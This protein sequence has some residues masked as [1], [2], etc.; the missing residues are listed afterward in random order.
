MV[1]TRYVIDTQIPVVCA[2]RL[3]L[4]KDGANRCLPAS[5]VCRSILRCEYCV[6][7]TLR[8]MRCVACITIHRCTGVSTAQYQPY[9][10]L[11]TALIGGPKDVCVCACVSHNS[12]TFSFSFIIALAHSMWNI[13]S[14]MCQCVVACL[15]HD[16]VSQWSR[17]VCVVPVPVMSVSAMRSMQ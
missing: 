2:E 6:S 8:A 12:R 9:G 14:C 1:I 13:Y 3:L 5:I 15:S 16:C 10:L 11:H 17:G 7:S 4:H